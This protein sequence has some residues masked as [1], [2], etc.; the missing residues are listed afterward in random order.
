MSR[1]SA[2][3]R[4]NEPEFGSLAAALREQADALATLRQTRQT[5]PPAEPRPPQPSPS[6]TRIISP[7]EAMRLAFEQ[8]DGARS[9]K[10]LSE[11]LSLDGIAIIGDA[12]ARADRD[13]LTLEADD[14]FCH[15][16]RGTK[17]LRP[18]RRR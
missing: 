15:E 3:Q 14:I 1:S 10:F 13:R 16:L 7:E 4:K 6:P 17:P 9:R 18:A 11:G 5:P 8:S 2:K 12:P